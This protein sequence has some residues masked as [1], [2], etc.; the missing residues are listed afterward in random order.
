MYV[1]NTLIHFLVNRKQF[2]FVEEENVR[3]VR[4][5]TGMEGRFFKKKK[6]RE[7]T[8]CVRVQSR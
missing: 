7:M 4:P 2:L 1:H 3:G 6:E 5:E 8:D